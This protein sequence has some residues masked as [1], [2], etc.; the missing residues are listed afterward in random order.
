MAGS[1]GQ[2]QVD[3][4]AEQ[5]L[6]NRIKQQHEKVQ[7]IQ[8]LLTNLSQTILPKIIQNK[9]LTLE[10]VQKSELAEF[11]SQKIV[12]E[13]ERLQQQVEHLEK[14]KKEVKEE[15]DR[16]I[17]VLDNKISED[18]AKNLTEE[19]KRIQNAVED[20]NK[21]L[22]KIKE[23]VQSSL[24]LKEIQWDEYYMKIA[25][26]AALRSKDPRTPVS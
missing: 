26:L 25:C 22:E 18:E 14:S 5:I 6:M 10:D 2:P 11:E 23:R 15:Q 16:F 13:V 12:H 1:E 7:E 17:K 20:V 21:E 8:Q 19:M 24:H 9:M 4:S 3:L